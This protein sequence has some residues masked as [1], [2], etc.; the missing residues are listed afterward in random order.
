MRSN[1]RTI[2]I[3]STLALAV[4]AGGSSPAAD[5]AA[6]QSPS[7]AVYPDPDAEGDVQDETSPSPAPTPEVAPT[8]NA[9]V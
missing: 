6:D 2:A 9:K 7:S 5:A 4:L 8:M 1:H 3:T